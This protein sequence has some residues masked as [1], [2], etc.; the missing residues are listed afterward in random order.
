M[1]SVVDGSV[2]GDVVA[3]PTPDPELDDV[4]LIPGDAVGPTGTHLDDNVPPSSRATTSRPRRLPSLSNLVLHSPSSIVGTPLD[5]AARF[6]YPFP[7]S[8][9]G[10]SPELENIYSP[11]LAYSPFLSPGPSR[12]HHVPVPAIPLLTPSFSTPV[13]T[14]NPPALSLP[15]FHLSSLPSR[16]HKKKTHP[17][18]SPMP[19]EPPV[20]P[21]LAQ[22]RDRAGLRIQNGKGTDRTKEEEDLRSRSVD[23]G[24]STS[25][26]LTLSPQNGSS[27]DSLPGEYDD[28]LRRYSFPS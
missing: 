13:F 8:S 1:S 24:S 2:N 23:D 15:H 27:S 12:F 18:L 21:R 4:M 9:E 26:D 14:T 10:S 25:G 6:E 5:P 22:K 7:P 17:R 16:A 20:P 19:R 28:Q 11:S 3:G